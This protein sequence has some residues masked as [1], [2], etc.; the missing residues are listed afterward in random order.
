MKYKIIVHRNKVGTNALLT[1][2]EVERRQ[3]AETIYALTSEYPGCS[4]SLYPEE[5]CV[6]IKQASIKKQ[7]ETLLKPATAER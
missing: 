5:T 7:L 3:L 4:I 2:R 1:R 6:V